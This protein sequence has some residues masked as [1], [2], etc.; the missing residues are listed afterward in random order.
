MSMHIS[1]GVVGPTPKFY[2]LTEREREKLQFRTFLLP[3]PLEAIKL[4][5][6]QKYTQK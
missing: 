3:V 2:S 5:N 4:F 6:N 1:P